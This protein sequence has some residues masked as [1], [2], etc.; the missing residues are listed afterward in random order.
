[1]IPSAPPK[2]GSFFAFLNELI[3]LRLLLSSF[4]LLRLGDILLGEKLCS[5]VLAV[6]ASSP[7]F[8]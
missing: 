7:S 6:F 4:D 3:D 8:F 5:V 1:M 2:S